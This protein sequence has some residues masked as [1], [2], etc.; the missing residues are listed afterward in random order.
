MRQQTNVPSSVISS[1]SMHLG[2]LATA[3]HAVTTG[4][5][6]TVYYKP[7]TSPAEFIVPF[8]QYMESVKNKYPVGLRFKMRF[9]GE[10]APEQRFTGTIVGVD[11]ADS[12]RWPSSKWRCLK[13]RWDENSSV[14]RPERVSP[15]K[16]EPASS[17]TPSSIPVSRP[18]RTRTN[19]IS[20]SSDSGLLAREGP[21]KVASEPS[22][23]NGFSRVFQAQE[24]SSL[25]G[26]FSEQESE[27]AQK[28]MLRHV[29]QDHDKVNDVSSQKKFAPENWRPLV[30]HEPAYA[31]LLAGFE[32]YKPARGLSA[33]FGDKGQDSSAN[34]LKRQ[35]Q[36][37][38][39][40]FNF[41]GSHW[42]MMSTSSNLNML[43]PSLKDAALTDEMTFQ[44][45]GLSKYGGLN[46][47]PV[48]QSI[49]DERQHLG[50]KPQLTLSQSEGLQHST[51]QNFFSQQ[52]EAVKSKGDGNCKLFGFP[53]VNN[54]VEPGKPSLHVDFTSDGECNTP[55]SHL[56]QRL[57]SDQQFGQVR[58]AIYADAA[59]VTNEGDKP[60]QACHQCLRETHSKVHSGA[61]RS[62]TKVH[63]QGVALG[64]SVD[65]AKFKGYDELIAELDQMFEFNGEL[66]GPQKNWLVV[67]IDIVDDM[68]LVGD[69]P[70]Q[71]FCNVV[72]KIFIYTKE[73]VQRMNPGTL[74]RPAEE[75]AAVAE[76][77]TAAC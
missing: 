68:M 52:R 59:L 48:L 61:M 31:D 76:E 65:L 66:M 30:R 20:P 28:P 42:S 25:K 22:Q 37:P 55:V 63:K 49:R 24:A 70:W 21:S 7:R 64:R 72:R 73:E 54:Q 47:Y 38:D 11:Y 1:H 50:L 14:L 67:Y 39:G 16:I 13:V 8:D 40:K 69:E 71:E 9:E 51:V 60:S 4:T 10:E 44:N 18:K 75:I 57:E 46:G 32:S 3:W 36:D 45:P 29:L 33:P 77:K 27:T 26:Q 6:F 12:G 74:N 2:V 62:C 43:D 15:W 58:G 17:S 53:L 5:L 23:T 56:S 35:F 34:H 19:I 41:L